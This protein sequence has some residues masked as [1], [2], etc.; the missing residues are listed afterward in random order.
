MYVAWGVAL[1]VFMAASAYKRRSIPLWT[2]TIVS[3]FGLIGTDNTLESAAPAL[4][5]AWA[6]FMPPSARLV[7]LIILTGRDPGWQSA[8]ALAAQCLGNALEFYHT[9]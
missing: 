7:P 2:G 5:V 1:G 9:Q 6:T 3:L 4:M 8:C